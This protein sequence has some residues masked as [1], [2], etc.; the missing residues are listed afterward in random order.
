MLFRSGSDPTQ[1]ASHHRPL[2]FF[3]SFPTSEQS[4][5]KIGLAA[6]LFGFWNPYIL[7]ESR[8]FG[9]YA[10]TKQASQSTAGGGRWCSHCRRQ[11][12]QPAIHEWHMR[13]QGIQS[14][15]NRSQN[16]VR[17][18]RTHN[19][20]GTPLCIHGASIHSP[21]S[22]QQNS[23][24]AKQQNN[25]SARRLRHSLIAQGPQH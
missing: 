7:T 22:Q 9:Q 15:E 20:S 5:A 25:P 1:D 24:T 23:K 10:H 12:M 6:S 18:P 21:A 19:D 8:I 3:F 4:M 2:L 17:G 14:A 13:E 16:A 11:S